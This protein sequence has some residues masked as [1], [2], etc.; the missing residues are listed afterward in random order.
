MPGSAG[1]GGTN[2]RTLSRRSEPGSLGAVSN[3]LPISS[4]YRN[5]PDAALAEDERDRLGARLN[6][7]YTEG[8]LSAEDYHT[9]LD[10][11]FAATRLGELVPVVEGLPPAATYETPAIVA[12][13]GG[14]PGELAPSRT[15]TGVSLLLVL[16]VA[17]ALVLIAILFLFAV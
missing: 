12:S 3:E 15:A 6:A 7:A 10:T 16:G 11:L 5:T 4:R 2:R 1:P 13:T 9:R 14:Q 17:A 8:T